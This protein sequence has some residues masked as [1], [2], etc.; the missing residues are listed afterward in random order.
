MERWRF[1]GLTTLLAVLFLAGLFLVA[2]AGR[3][4]M[5]TAAEDMQHAMARRILVAE[6]RER[7]TDVAFAYQAFLLTGRAEALAPLRNAGPR[8]NDV[9]ESLLVSY[10]DEPRNAGA[11]A[12]QLRYLAGVVTGAVSQAHRVR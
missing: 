7:V 6:L 8:I 3:T 5:Q 1:F 11:A 4:R 9:A 10:S 12:R 2:E